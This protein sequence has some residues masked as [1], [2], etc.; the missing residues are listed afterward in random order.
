MSAPVSGE[1]LQ[2]APHPVLFSWPV[3]ISTSGEGKTCP[4]VKNL[5]EE[6]AH[7]KDKHG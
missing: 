6:L 1:D 5:V 3:E 2:V 4:P 7:T